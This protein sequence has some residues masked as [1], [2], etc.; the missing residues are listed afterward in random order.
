MLFWK[1]LQIYRKHSMH[2]CSNLGLQILTPKS[3]ALG[4]ATGWTRDA[5]YWLAGSRSFTAISCEKPLIS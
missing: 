5:S 3:G 4:E 2:S 1:K